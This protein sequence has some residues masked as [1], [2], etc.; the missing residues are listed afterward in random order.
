MANYRAREEA[1][2]VNAHWLKVLR[3][4]RDAEAADQATK[5]RASVAKAQR[6]NKAPRPDEGLRP[7]RLTAENDR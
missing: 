3:L 5:A 2:D 7:D 6:A 4:T 1:S